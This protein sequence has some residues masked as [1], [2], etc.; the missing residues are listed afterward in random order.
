MLVQRVIGMTESNDDKEANIIDLIDKVIQAEEEAYGPDPD[1]P[2]TELKIENL[3]LGDVTSNEMISQSKSMSELSEAG[4]DASSNI[5]ASKYDV[6]A[7]VHREDLPKLNEEPEAFDSIDINEHEKVTFFNESETS[8]RTDESGYSDT[9]DYHHLNESAEERIQDS[10]ESLNVLDIVPPS[11]PAN[12][13]LVA[14]PGHKKSFTISARA[15]NPVLFERHAAKPRGSIQSNSSQDEN[16]NGNIVFGS[17]R[18]MKFMSKLNN[19]F[20]NK[21]PTPED[22]RLK[23]SNSTGDVHE[24][25][26]KEIEMTRSALFL[27]LKKEIMSKTVLKP[28]Q[29]V[30]TKQPDTPHNS[31]EES[32]DEKESL[33]KEELK[34]KLEN[35]LSAGGPRI[36]KPRLTKSNPPTPEEAPIDSSTGSLPKPPKLDLNDTLKRQKDKFGEVLNSFRL[37]LNTDSDPL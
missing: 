22:N 12:I 26:E 4:S 1:I 33:S 3:D 13:N 36:L 34:S 32:E 14:N 7:Q 17:V 10:K 18:Q 2:L 29:I 19:I 37:S 11:S 16:S 20:Q 35:L 21:I 25:A 24:S 15:T 28:V 23:R 5:I 31:E 6:V 30:I 8:S 27:D 9:T